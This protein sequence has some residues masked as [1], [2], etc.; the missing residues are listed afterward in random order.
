MIENENTIRYV[1]F[2]IILLCLAVAI[3]LEGRLDKKLDNTNRFFYA[4][5]IWKGLRS[6][7]LYLLIILA[8]FMFAISSVL[9]R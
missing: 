2:G 6:M 1:V 9:F 3:Y 5:N 8:L 4:P 7:E